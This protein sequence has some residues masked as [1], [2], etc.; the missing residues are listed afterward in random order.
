VAETESIIGYA[1]LD[2]FEECYAYCEDACLIGDSEET[3][4]E[5]TEEA[6]VGESFR[7]EPVT[8][9]R[10]MND[11]GCSCGEYALELEA[12]ARFEAAAA[13]AGVEYERQ[14]T[15][16]LEGVVVVK[17]HHVKLQPDW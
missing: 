6:T 7:I 9:S 12:W 17:V 14:E 16:W 13:Q 11:F 4:R 10:M 15:P 5:F 8:L 1:G 2:L 3:A